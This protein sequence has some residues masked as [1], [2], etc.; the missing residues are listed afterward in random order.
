MAAIND[1]FNDLVEAKDRVNELHEA[2][3]GCGRSGRPA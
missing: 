3:T 2:I 1:R